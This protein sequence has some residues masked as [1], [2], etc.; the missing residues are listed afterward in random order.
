MTERI[1][2]GFL[3]CSKLLSSYLQDLVQILLLIF[4]DY[5]VRLPPY[6]L[7]FQLVR[8]DLSLVGTFNLQHFVLN[9]TCLG[10]YLYNIS[11]L[12]TNQRFANRRFVGNFTL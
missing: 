8:S 1:L 12:C 4:S 9:H 5:S 2:S 6:L 3:Q 10:F 7:L 11:D